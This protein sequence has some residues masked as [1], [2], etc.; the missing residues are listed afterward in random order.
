MEKKHEATTKSRVFT[1]RFLSWI[2]PI[3]IQ[4]LLSA[5]STLPMS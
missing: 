5:A 4:N 1:A 2:L 3:V